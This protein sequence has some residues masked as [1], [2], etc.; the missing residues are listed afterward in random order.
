MGIQEREHVDVSN[1]EEFEAWLMQNH[2]TALG[3]WVVTH[4]KASGK[5][6]PTYDQMVRVALCWGWVDSVPGKVDELRTKLY[7]SPRKLGSAWSQSNKERVQQLIESGDMRPAGLAKVEQAKQNGTWN[8]IDSAQNAEVP[9]DLAAAFEALEGS[10]EY[11]DAFPKGVRKQ[12]LEWISQ[13]KTAETRD[14]RILETATLAQKNV[15]ANQW[16]DKNKP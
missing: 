12:I 14:K 3:V 11:F 10:K 2:E 8:L 4:K 5:S 15:R 16:R 1:A 6:A 7:S 9:A 13:A